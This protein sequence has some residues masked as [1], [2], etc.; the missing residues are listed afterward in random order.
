L[1]G[2]ITVGPAMIAP[3]DGLKLTAAPRASTATQMPV[4]GHA[5]ARS[6]WMPSMSTGA[7]AVFDVGLNVTSCPLKSM[8]T[9]WVVDAHE[10]LSIVPPF[11]S[12]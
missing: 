9:H 5:T 1:Y 10:S 7:W 2:S 12:R 6:S 11:V 8:P 4:E 3:F